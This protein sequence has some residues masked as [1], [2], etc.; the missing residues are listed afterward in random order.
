MNYQPTPEDIAMGKENLKAQE[1]VLGPFG[2]SEDGDDRDFGLCIEDSES[3]DENDEEKTIVKIN[4]YGH[5]NEKQ[6]SSEVIL[7]TGDPNPNFW[8]KRSKDI[9]Q[10]VYDI[11]SDEEKGF[12]NLF[13]ACQ[14]EGI[15]VE[16]YHRC[17]A[18]VDNH[19]DSNTGSTINTTKT[20]NAAAEKLLDNPYCNMTDHEL[21]MLEDA[22]EICSLDARTGPEHGMYEQDAYRMAHKLIGARALSEMGFHPAD[23]VIDRNAFMFMKKYHGDSEEVFMN[24]KNA[25]A[26]IKEVKN[27]R[28]QSGKK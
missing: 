5:A 16:D 4:Y 1:K 21:A 3:D 10:T 11:D 26:F 15:S 20:N 27:Q 17:S 22:I 12:T 24:R 14:N 28:K 23:S 19:K 2:V 8:E 13:L 6:L 25:L 7:P 9:R 18:W